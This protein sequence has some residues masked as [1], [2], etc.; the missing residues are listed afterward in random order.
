MAID[1]VGFNV[2]NFHTNIVRYL[3]FDNNT[4]LLIYNAEEQ[5]EKRKEKLHGAI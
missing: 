3:I 4:F 1:K 2:Y 5:L